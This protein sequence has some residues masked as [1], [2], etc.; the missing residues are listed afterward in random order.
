MLGHVV[1]FSAVFGFGSTVPAPQWVAAPPS[2]SLNLASQDFV[3]QY[4]L[5]AWDDA[6]RMYKIDRGIQRKSVGSGESSE[7]SFEKTPVDETASNEI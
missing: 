2:S 4:K 6:S 7:L 1:L 3:A 5:D